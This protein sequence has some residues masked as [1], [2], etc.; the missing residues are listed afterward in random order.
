MISIMD[1]RLDATWVVRLLLDYC[2][3]PV[4]TSQ[5]AV[6]TVILIFLGAY[7]MRCLLFSVIDRLLPPIADL[8]TITKPAGMDSKETIKQGVS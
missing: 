5:R 8:S 1:T 7:W 4:S 2:A 6:W 3:D